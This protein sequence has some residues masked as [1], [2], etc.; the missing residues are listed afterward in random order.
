MG[1][2]YPQVPEE[3]GSRWRPFVIGLAVVAIALAVIWFR[4][5]NVRPAAT[6]QETVDPYAA[7]LQISNLHLSSA[8]NFVG[9][10]VTY[11]QGQ[12]ANVGTKIVAGVEVEV[13]FRNSLGEV[14]Q[15]ESQPLRVLQTT[16]GHA[17]FA[18]LS[19][20]PLRPNGVREF[21]LTFEHISADWNQGFPELRFTKITTK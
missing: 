9:G 3:T 16:L 8:Q 5:R 14:V 7:S 13:V 4:S 20:A 10:T 15:K 1:T 17:D 6:P 21:R 11:L 18:L 12:I 19:T 2:F